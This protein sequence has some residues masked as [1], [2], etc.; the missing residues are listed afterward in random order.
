ME[1]RQRA[2]LT[3]TNRSSDLIALVAKARPRG[4]TSCESRFCFCRQT[5]P[6]GQETDIRPPSPVVRNPFFAGLVALAR[7]SDPIPSRTRPSNAS[8]PMVLCLKTW[9]SRSSPGLQRTKQPFLLASPDPQ[10]RRAATPAGPERQD[11][12]PAK[13]PQQK[14]TQNRT[15]LKAEK[16]SQ[17]LG[18]GWSSPVARQAHNLKAA[19]SNPAPA[20]TSHIIH[21]R[22]GS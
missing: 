10:R 8:A 4:Q 9:E 18:A 14:A 3:G 15:E 22:N 17:T 6:R 19:G 16:P 11:P 12:R 2:Q 21:P 13:P 1:A 20:T 5:D 7:R